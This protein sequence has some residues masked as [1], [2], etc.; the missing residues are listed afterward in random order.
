MRER[1]VYHFLESRVGHKGHFGVSAYLD[2]FA[3][4]DVHAFAFSHCYQFEGAKTFDFYKFVFK[5]TLLN[6]VEE[7]AHEE[8]GFLFSQAFASSKV[9][10]QFL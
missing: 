5:N 4:F 6:E 8:F 9:L 3:R 2:A 10:G 1:L 7:S